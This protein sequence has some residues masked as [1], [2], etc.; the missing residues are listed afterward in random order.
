MVVLEAAHIKPKGNRK[1]A[2]SLLVGSN[3]SWGYILQE[4]KKCLVKCA[5]CHRRE[6]AAQLGYGKVEYKS[7][8]CGQLENPTDT[9]NY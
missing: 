5:N 7:R 2:I 1:K 8:S 9:T 4:L 3:R 6:T